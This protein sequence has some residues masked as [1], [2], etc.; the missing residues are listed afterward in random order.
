MRFI[1]SIVPA[2]MAGLLAM[3]LLSLP[4]PSLASTITSGGHTTGYGCTNGFACGNG[5][6]TFAYDVPVSPGY[7]A[8]VGTVD[9]D[10]VNG[11]VDLDFDLASATYLDVAGADNGVDEIVFTNVN[12]SATGLAASHLG[13]GVYSV[14]GSVT[15]DGTYE[16]LLGGGGVVGAT[17]FLL[18]ANLSA[19]Q[20]T[21]SGA[22]VAC[23][24]DFGPGGPFALDVGA[25]PVS[26]R[27]IQGFNVV[28]APEP[29]TLS[30]LGAGLLSLAI[31][32]QR[33]A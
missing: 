18:T 20:C 21:E 11:L 3:A 31:A 10:D 12:Y 9:F 19:G 6:E 1:E 23:T 16:Q 22:V 33:R 4:L 2:G 28:S 17:D 13:G 30:L 29:G 25:A 26:R 24:F 14:S 8:V 15:V 27:F 5:S 7:G 32:K